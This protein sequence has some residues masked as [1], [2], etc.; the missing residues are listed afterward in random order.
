MTQEV[1]SATL[2]DKKDQ[3]VPTALLSEALALDLSAPPSTLAKCTR[4]S[5][6]CLCDKLICSL[7]QPATAELTSIPPW[8]ITH[9]I[10][11]WVT[12]IFAGQ[13]R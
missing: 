3:A 11:F 2:R 12:V 8:H 7:N 6:S 9:I 5:A 4:V 1:Y 13:E 10:S